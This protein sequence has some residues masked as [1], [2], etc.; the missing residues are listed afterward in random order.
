M[1]TI[2]NILV[3]WQAFRPAGVA[4][5]VRQLHEVLNAAAERIRSS[6]APESAQE[7]AYALLQP[8]W[9]NGEPGPPWF[10]RMLRLGTSGDNDRIHFLRFW[11]AMQELCRRLEQRQGKAESEPLA[12]E[13]SVL[14]DA[15]LRHSD[16]SGTLSSSWFVSEAT[17]ARATSADEAAWALLIEKAAAQRAAPKGALGGRWRH[18]SEA[19][20]PLEEASGLLFEWLQEV[21]LDYASGERGAKRHAVCD[22]AGCSGREACFHLGCRGWE[23]E[24]ALLS[25]YNDAGGT[26]G[27]HGWSSR[28]AK[29]RKSEAEVECP[30]C[31]EMYKSKAMPVVTGCCFQVLCSD[32]KAKLTQP[33]GFH[34][35]F[36]RTVEGAP[37]DPPQSSQQTPPTRSAVAS[38]LRTSSLETLAGLLRALHPA[39]SGP[40]GA[41]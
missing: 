36:C 41:L 28:G 19:P 29:L 18:C 26:S 1:E 9:T 17:Q 37:K 40:R 25:F 3:D 8:T 33:G 14:R 34:C 38:N 23:V 27:A 12:E 32:C 22:V 2:G 10:V 7:D 6:Q 31:A 39:R 35:P 5:P 15:V 4:A 20:W 24:A 13:V 11:Q 30:I 16:I 21:T